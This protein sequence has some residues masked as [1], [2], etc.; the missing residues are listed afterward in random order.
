MLEHPA[1]L[2]RVYL[3]AVAGDALQEREILA[4]DVFPELER[5][6]VSLGLAIFRVEPEED[7]DLAR[8]CDEIDTCR[9]FVGI[10]GDR[11]GEPPPRISGD[12]RSRPDG[13]ADAG[14]STVDLEI[15]H[16]LEAPGMRCFFYLLDPDGPA[17]DERLAGLK[18][19]LR[20]G[21][22][23]V[24]GD[25]SVSSGLEGLEPFARR[26]L[27][28]LWTALR[29]GT[30]EAAPVEPPQ[31][32]A[33]RGP[34]Q[35]PRSRSR[36]FLW[37]GSAAAAVLVVFLSMPVFYSSKKLATKL[38]PTTATT[39]KVSQGPPPTPLP[40]PPVNALAPEVSLT[41]GNGTDRG[42]EIPAEHQGREF[43]TDEPVIAAVPVADLPA[44][45]SL[46]LRW[47]GPDG[48]AVFEETQTVPAGPPGLTFQLR[49]GGRPGAYRAEVWIEG[50]KA[51]VQGFEL[52]R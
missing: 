23:G 21:G 4:R 48:K 12:P 31:P 44:G 19:L 6:A 45:T 9:L 3:A 35:P 29:A 5:R 39:T 30:L 34:G 36:R 42:G 33:T 24:V 11:Y 8:R 50:Q 47:I 25:D 20:S 13:L 26:V 17:E 46:Q 2:V 15:H 51:A 41:L 1:T 22:Q 18:E 14:R 7:W 28:D 10:L 37:A 16:A 40:P 43:A 49:N 52:K 32:Q 38:G 27:E